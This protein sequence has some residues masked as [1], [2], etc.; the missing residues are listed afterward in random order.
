MKR[1]GNIFEKI[2]NIENIELAHK[3][4]SRG[5]SK[6]ESVKKVEGDKENKFEEIISVLK[7]GYRLGLKDYKH[8]KIIDKG[9]ERDL[10]KLPYFPH[11]IIQW[12]IV[13]VVSDDFIKSYTTCT[14]A[15]IKGRGIH[16]ALVK[17][18]KD[19]KSDKEGTKY[20]LKIDIK[21]FYPNINN[22]ILYEKLERKFKDKEFLEL[23]HTIV[24]SMGNK[25][26]PIGSL[27]SQYLANFYLSSFDHYC[28]EVLKIKYYYRYMDDIT[29]MHH[30]KSYLRS[31]KENFDKIF[32]DEYDLKIKENWQVFPVESRGID[33]LGYRFFHD[34]VIL[35]R[36][37]YKK[38]KK[39][40]N[41]GKKHKAWASYY[42]WCKH[43][44]I[45]RF[46]L[47]QGVDINEL[48]DR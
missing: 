40:L 3:K 27:L 15:S 35:R 1:K 38:A 26:I 21:K 36:H 48:H 32:L 18:K 16:S 45:N 6:Y 7:K 11:R 42:G 14:Y 34:K 10:Y 20:C 31:L 43:A 17:L 23:I 24:F 28:K 39:V 37:I 12:A 44:S 13:N 33:F 46:I 9:K 41:K 5:K 8:S 30:D 22:E 25:G 47:K 29:I 19:L 4:S 2:I